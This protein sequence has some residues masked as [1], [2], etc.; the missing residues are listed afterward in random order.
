[1]GARLRHG[2]TFRKLALF[3]IGAGEY[4]K[5]PEE[6][7]SDLD[8]EVHEHPVLRGTIWKIHARLEHHD[9]KGLQILHQTP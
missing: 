7:W 9:Q 3:R 5:F 4:E 6:F 1:M 2:D 8:M